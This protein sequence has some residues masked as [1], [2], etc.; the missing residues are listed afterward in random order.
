VEAR[1]AVL[2]AC[3]KCGES[4]PLEHFRVFQRQGR[5]CRHSHCR[6][7][8]NARLREYRRRH[9]ER[10]AARSK[11]YRQ[12]N[13]DKVRARNIAKRGGATLE[14]YDAMFAQQGGVCAICK[15][16]P[17]DGKHLSVDH[18]H[19]T[20]AIRGLLCGKCNSGLGMFADEPGRL[21]A[22]VNYLKEIK[23]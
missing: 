2:K 22:A 15:Q 13:P 19:A 7:C 5:P 1:D 20:G 8:Q 14:D 21:I 12:R 4:W 23:Q 17:L 11:A 18:C 16:P 3:S 9:P 10:E 6:A